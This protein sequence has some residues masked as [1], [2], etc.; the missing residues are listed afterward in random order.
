MRTTLDLDDAVLKAVKAIARAKRETA[1]RVISSLAR[2][3]MT[4]PSGNR[5]IVMKDGF[6]LLRKTGAVVTPELVEQL[7]DR[8]DMEDAGLDIES[9]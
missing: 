8:A 9:D 3:A 1:G 6:P 5:E 4:Q 7:L 2:Q